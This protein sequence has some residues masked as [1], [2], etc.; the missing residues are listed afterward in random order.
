MTVIELGSAKDNAEGMM[1]MENNKLYW[2]SFFSDTEE[3]FPGFDIG[4][5]RSRE[6]A[7][8]VASRYRKEVPGFKDYDCDPSIMG[9]PVWNDADVADKVYIYQGWNWDENGDET[10]C[11]ISSCFVSQSEAEH[12]FKDAQERIPRQ[13][14]V[15]NCHVIG[16]CHWQEGFVREFHGGTS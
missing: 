4:I 3:D 2:L 10:D 15:L 1:N 12:Y 7:E 5:F 11:L 16:Q 14:W 6:E 13:E 8:R 9:I